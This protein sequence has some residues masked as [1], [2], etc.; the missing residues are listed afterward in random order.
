LRISPKAS[1]EL[2]GH[3]DEIGDANSNDKLSLDRALHVKEALVAQGIPAS[4]LSTR[5]LGNQSPLR[6]GKT[7]WD[8]SSNRAVSFDVT[9]P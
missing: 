1:V 3:A 7:D 4:A 5:G 6:A 8:R 9:A 2:V